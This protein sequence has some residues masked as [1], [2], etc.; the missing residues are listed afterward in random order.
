MFEGEYDTKEVRSDGEKMV[1]RGIG[2]V[3]IMPNRAQLMPA[4]Y[5]I[6]EC[7]ADPMRIQ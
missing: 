3:Y 5:A 7:F 1:Y 6:L 4:G 2:D